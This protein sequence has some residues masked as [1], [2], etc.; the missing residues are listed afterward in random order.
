MSSLLALIV[1]CT[2]I[3]KNLGGGLRHVSGAAK[4][5]AVGIKGIIG[6]WKR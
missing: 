2:G 5:L 4:V 6:R 1:W 3:A